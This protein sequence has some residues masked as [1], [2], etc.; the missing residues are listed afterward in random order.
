MPSARHS[1]PTL[2]PG[3]GAP[4]GGIAAE[5]FTRGDLGALKQGGSDVFLRAYGP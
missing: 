2:P 4:D 1:T 3:S 5:G